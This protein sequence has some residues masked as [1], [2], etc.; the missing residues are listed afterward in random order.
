MTTRTP[1]TPKTGQDMARNATNTAATTEKTKQDNKTAINAADSITSK[2]MQ[3]NP[4][5]KPKWPQQIKSAKSQWNKLSE[6]ELLKV[7]GDPQ[8]LAALIQKH[9]GLSPDVAKEQ[10]KSFMQKQTA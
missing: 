1:T 2:P 4:T 10:A 9:Y 7:D 5:N 6:A 3:A 8:Q